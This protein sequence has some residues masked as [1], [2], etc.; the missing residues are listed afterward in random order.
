MRRARPLAIAA[1]ATVIVA[2]IA[3]LAIGGR[4]FVQ[5][6]IKALLLA[7]S[8]LAMS[9]TVAARLFAGLVRATILS[10]RRSRALGQSGAAAAEFVIVVIPFLL[11]LFGIMQMALASLARVLVSYSAFSAVRAAIVFVPEASDAEAANQVGSGG[12]ASDDFKGSHK[13]TLMRN[14]AAYAMIP[15]SPAID[16]VL[17]DAAR[18]LPGYLAGRIQ[19]GLSPAD[20]IQGKLVGLAQPLIDAFNQKVQDELGQVAQGLLSKSGAQQAISDWINQQPG[21]SAT[22]KQALATAAS[23]YLASQLSG[24]LQAGA[25][26]IGD[27]VKSA[28][29]D[30]L[31]GPLG[32]FKD[33]INNAVAGALGSLASAG[34]GA[35]YSVGRALDQGFGANDDGAGGA[36]LRSLRKLIYARLGTTVT[37]IDPA[38][39]NYK[40]SFGWGDPVTARVTY[41]F[42]CQIPL[43][44]RFAGKQFY[45]LPAGATSELATGPLGP[46][47]TVGLPG[48]FMVMQAQHTMVNQ[49]RP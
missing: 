49:G 15:A 27:F 46:V 43:A 23:G 8:L 41:L 10:L 25:G 9:I 42:Y 6:H 17:A 5:Q 36:L 29:A 34:G 1:A 18:N 12:N 44:N 45:D 22:Q 39:G 26:Q 7:A 38:T 2:V 32:A 35:Q 40:S 3:G 21:L 20:F 31:S 24:A 48:F 11:L 13:A 4:D 47:A 19:H 16:V 28:V 37:L 14:A 33:Q 30:T